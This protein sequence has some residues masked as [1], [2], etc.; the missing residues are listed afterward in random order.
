MSNYFTNAPHHIVNTVGKKIKQL[1]DYLL[2]YK[3]AGNT[4]KAENKPPYLELDM[5]IKIQ[6]ENRVR[7]ILYHQTIV[8][9]T[10]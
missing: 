7:Y 8:P 5:I 6:S 1:I 4:E 2:K 9:R 10:T 3:F